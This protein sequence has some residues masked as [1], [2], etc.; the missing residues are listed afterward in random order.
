MELAPW[1]ASWYA[2]F[3]FS[4]VHGFPHENPN[5]DAKAIPGFHG[6]SNSVMQH[7]YSFIEFSLSIGLRHEYDTMNF[8]GI[9]LKG[10]A[11]MWFEIL[12]RRDFIFCRV[13]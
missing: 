2:P 8:F 1:L 10:D 3:D 11:R 7:I 13:Y 5:V 6:Y 12:A 9:S 4:N